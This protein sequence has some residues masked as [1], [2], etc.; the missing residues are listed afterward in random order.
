MRYSVAGRTAATAATART[1]AAHLW[2]PDTTDRVN[3]NEIHIVSTTAGLSNLCIARTT[4]IGTAGSTVTPDLDNAHNRGKVPNS[5]AVLGLALFSVMP[6]VDGSDL[7]RWNLPAVIGAGLMWV[8]SEPIEIPPG[9]GLAIITPV[10]VI[11]PA[12]D[13]T[14][15]FTD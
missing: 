2:N 6:T 5:A 15:S 1:V 4:T 10:A 8:F 13:V 12:S 11:L 7:L 3:V 14:Y 9:T